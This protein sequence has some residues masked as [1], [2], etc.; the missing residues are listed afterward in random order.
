MSFQASCYDVLSPVQLFI[1]LFYAL[2]IN[3]NWCFEV[4]KRIKSTKIHKST[5]HMTP[6]TYRKSSEVIYKQQEVFH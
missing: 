4:Q 6:A 1:V 3:V 2:T 5:I